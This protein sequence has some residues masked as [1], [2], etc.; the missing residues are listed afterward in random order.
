MLSYLHAFHAGNFADVQKHA[1][2][3]LGLTMM[4]VKASPIACFDTHAGSAEYD[5]GI[6]TLWRDR[7]R[8]AAPDWAG[9]LSILA[10]RN[11]AGGPLRIYPGSPAWM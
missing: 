11:P 7:D 5:L 3:Y 10:D 2:L 6:Q 8:L 9:F 4:Q 1:G